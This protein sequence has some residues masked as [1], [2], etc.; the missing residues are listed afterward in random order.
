MV[1][2]LPILT[3]GK[4]MMAIELR[5]GNWRRPYGFWE[6]ARVVELKSV[7]EKLVGVY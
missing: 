4:K 7:E 3:M 1:S 6:P 2:E 5:R